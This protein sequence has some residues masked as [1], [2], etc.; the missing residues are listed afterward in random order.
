MNQSANNSNSSRPHYGRLP[1]AAELAALHN[2]RRQ[3]AAPS[4]QR[5]SLPRKP[6]SAQRI[7]SHRPSPVRLKPATKAAVRPASPP[8]RIQTSPVVR[9]SL[10]RHKSFWSR[11]KILVSIVGIVIISGGI[12]AAIKQLSPAEQVQ[13]VSQTQKVQEPAEGQ[14]ETVPTAGT[15]N[16]YQAAANAPRILTIPKINITSRVLALG[17]GANN[18]PKATPNIFDTSW[19]NLSSEPGQLGTMIIQGHIHGPTK[20]GAFYELKK[21]AKDDII[22]IESGNSTEYTYKVTRTQIYNAQ[23]SDPA[24]VPAEDSNGKPNLILTTYIGQPAQITNRYTERLVV[25]ATLSQ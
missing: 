5:V 20:P 10:Y 11:R 12:A 16:S 3:R 19:Y 24:D 9:E 15:L 7:Q 2:P 13:G 6:D 18:Q 8:H 4:S 23:S 17:L 22:Q 14:D 1:T 25:F 21:L